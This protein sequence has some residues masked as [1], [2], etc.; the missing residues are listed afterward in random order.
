MYQLRSLVPVLLALSV[1]FSCESKNSFRSE[2]GV[3]KDLQGTWQWVP[4]YRTDLQE[5]WKFDN[6]IVTITELNPGPPSLTKVSTGTYS[7]K[8]TV[9][10]PYVFIEGV[11]SYN[12]KWVIIN[13]DKKVLTMVI[14]TKGTNALSQKEF[15]KK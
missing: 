14:T 11:Q 10:T 3:K 5:V 8:T 7:V 6:G 1:L 9:T 15:I 12:G 4:V 2:T 13:L